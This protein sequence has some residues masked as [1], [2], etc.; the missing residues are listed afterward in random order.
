MPEAKARKFTPR[1]WAQSGNRFWGTPD[2]VETLPPGFYNPV[3]LPTGPEMSRFEPKADDLLPLPTKEGEL[4][5]DEITRFW[6]RA[7]AVQAS[8]FIIKRGILMAGPPGTGK[9]SIVQLIAKRMIHAYPVITHD[10]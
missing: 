1:R 8:G 4:L 10:H 7:G 6:E 2:T 9:T 5:F 3:L